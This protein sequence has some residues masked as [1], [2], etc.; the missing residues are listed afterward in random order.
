MNPTK[1]CIAATCSTHGIT[2]QSVQETT[3]LWSKSADMFDSDRC[4][5]E[6]AVSHNLVSQPTKVFKDCFKK[7][8]IKLFHKLHTLWQGP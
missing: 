2:E 8:L 4:L 3:Q 5:P 7:G 6:P 1:T